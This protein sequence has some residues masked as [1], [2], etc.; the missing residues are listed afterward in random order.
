[1]SIRAGWHWFR[2]LP[3]NPIYLREKGSW[4]RPNPF[5]DQMIRFAPV[6]VLAGIG[7]GFCAGFGNPLLFGDNDELF[8]IWCLVCIPG[9]LLTMTTLYGLFIAPALT[10]PIISQERDS[11]TW[12][13]LLT[14]P[15]S[16]Q[17][18]VMAK[19]LGALARVRVWPILFLLTGFQG[20]IIFFSLVFIDGGITFWDW[21]IAGATAL[22]PW[23]EIFFAAFSGF[24]F[25]TL[26]RSA[27]VALASTYALI[28][29]F[30]LINSS[31]L[32]IGVVG[33]RSSDEIVAFGLG[34]VGPTAVY[35]CSIMALG[36]GIF[37]QANRLGE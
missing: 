21:L 8:A 9:I 13:I 15:Q 33:L 10:A 3:Q 34:S 2:H 18:I 12:S 11:G 31:L 29:A 28:V 25:S 30:K 7:L 5:Y 36:A 32:W 17:A 16:R 4:G 24:F 23:T 35:L 26:V 14:I 1:M 22:R 6:V 37:V 27:T 20:F 19:L